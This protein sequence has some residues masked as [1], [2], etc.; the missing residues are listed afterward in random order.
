M[1]KRIGRRMLAAT[2]AAGALFAPALAQAGE[3]TFWTWRQEDRAAY[4]ELFA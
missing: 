2:I 3:V 1:L 4:A